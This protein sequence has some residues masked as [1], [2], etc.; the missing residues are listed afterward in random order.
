MKPF[1]KVLKQTINEQA[2]YRILIDA[3]DAMIKD[4]ARRSRLRGESAAEI[5]MWQGDA[6]GKAIQMAI[7][8][9]SIRSFDEGLK[10]IKEYVDI[11]II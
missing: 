7:R 2:L 10:I 11:E 8:C 4:A 6:D 9:M 3:R 5:R 1:V